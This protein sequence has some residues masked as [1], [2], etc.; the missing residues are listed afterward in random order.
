MRL[1]QLVVFYHLLKLHNHNFP[2][3]DKPS[4]LRDNFHASLELSL[5]WC[6]S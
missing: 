1:H 3:L 4:N 6:Q 2:Y 5:M